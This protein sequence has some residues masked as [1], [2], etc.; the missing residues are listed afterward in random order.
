MSEINNTQVDL[1]VVMPIYNFIEYN[2]NYLKTSRSLW[3]HYR[4]EPVDAMV[5]SE[6]FKSK[7][8][9]IGNTPADANMKNVEIEVPLKYLNNF[10]RNLGMPLINC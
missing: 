5:N 6:S 8:K 9:A 2:D 7:T 3:Q 1:Y 10:C 4:D